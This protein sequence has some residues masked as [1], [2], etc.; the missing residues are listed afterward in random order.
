MPV[1][2]RDFAAA[3]AAMKKD[4]KRCSPD[5][6]RAMKTRILFVCVENSCRS[7]M[8]EGFARKLGGE[9]LDPW[10]AGSRPSGK[11]N[12]TAVAVMREKGIDLASQASKSLS[13]LPAGQWDNVITMG[14]GDACPFVASRRRT[15]WGVPD[16][17]GM[18][19]SGFRGVRDQIEAKVRDLIAEV[20]HEG[21]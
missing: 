11:I 20:R 15:D 3:L 19:L 1:L 13:D 10:S 14:C 17:K 21:A 4:P 2:R 6:P 7:Q 8:A 9:V 16:P 18:P 5:L 12:E